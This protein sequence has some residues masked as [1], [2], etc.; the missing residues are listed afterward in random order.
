MIFNDVCGVPHPPSRKISS[1]PHTFQKNS[2]LGHSTI[3]IYISQVH[4]FFPSILGFAV[5]MY[6]AT[7]SFASFPSSPLF[8][9]SCLIRDL[10]FPRVTFCKYISHFLV[11]L[12][13]LFSLVNMKLLLLTWHEG[14]LLYK[15][16]FHQGLL[17]FLFNH[18][19]YCI[20]NN[21]NI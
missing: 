10:V 3:S 4:S 8:L 21:N 5:Y 2:L 20:I 9:F 12:S 7:L 11:H 15:H 1:A 14:A 16:C 17:V 18:N 19:L 6:C 13:H